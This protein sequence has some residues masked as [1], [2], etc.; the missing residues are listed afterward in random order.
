MDP[1]KENSIWIVLHGNV[2]VIT[3][4]TCLHAQ[5]T[6]NSPKHVIVGCVV[7]LTTVKG[8]HMN[9]HVTN[10]RYRFILFTRM[11]YF[12]PACYFV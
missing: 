11:Q 6:Q 8:E 2:T 7:N 12:P 10:A 4:Y 3:S 1:F 9:Q 5:M